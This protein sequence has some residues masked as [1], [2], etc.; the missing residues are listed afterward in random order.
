MNPHVQFKN[1]RT[2]TGQV[3]NPP[4]I[5]IEQVQT[6][7]THVQLKNYRTKTGHVMNPQLKNYRT[8]TGQV[9]NPHVQFKK[10]QIKNWASNEST[11]Y[12][13]EHNFS[14]AWTA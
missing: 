11:H 12:K 4:G 3:M 7:Y 9:M 2:K 14:F 10:L 8:K 1:Y 5:K 6:R 13:I